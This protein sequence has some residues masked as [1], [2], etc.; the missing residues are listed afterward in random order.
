M[1]G[2]A[3]LSKRYLNCVLKDERIHSLTEYDRNLLARA[4]DANTLEAEE[5][6]RPV[7]STYGKMGRTA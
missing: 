1:V 6:R 5:L 7:S 4:R 3:P 2:K